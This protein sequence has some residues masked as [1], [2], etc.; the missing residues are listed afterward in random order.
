VYNGALDNAS[1][2]AFMLE[3]SK[4]I[5]SLG[6]P[7]RTII[8]IGFNAEE[9]G[10]LG[11]EHFA[12]KY[13]SQLKGAKVYNFD[14]IGSSAVPLTIMGGKGDN[15]KTEFLRS[16]MSTCIKE[17][18]DYNFIFED[19]SDHEAFRKNNIDAYL[20][21]CITA[22]LPKRI[23]KDSANKILCVDVPESIKKIIS[24]QL[25]ENRSVEFLSHIFYGDGISDIKDIKAVYKKLMEKYET[26]AELVITARLHCMSPCL[27]MG[28]PVI[29]V[30]DNC[31]PRMGWI[32]RYIP[33]YTP[34]TYSKI[35]WNPQPVSFE[36]T[37]DLMIEIAIDK[38][39]CAFKKYEKV[40]NLS[41]FY[42][43]RK[44]SEYGNFYVAQLKQLPKNLGNCF[45][46]IIW[47]TGQIGINAYN[48][49]T[50]IYPN[51]K[52]IAAVDSFC[53]GKFFEIDIQ[54]PDILKKYEDVYI[55][56]A[57]YSGEKYVKDF[58]LEL[59]KEN[60]KDYLSF[61]T[62]TG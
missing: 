28:I 51:S 61:A 8:F 40:C 5:K 12:I 7:E 15:D 50:E 60:I 55:F 48:V 17:K 23:K 9:F 2:I 19:S 26:E 46:Y 30:S 41:R 14:M 62:T 42:E 37:K 57:T 49:I 13:A 38:I 16:V 59:G 29:A 54:K 56:I 25:P 39:N 27:A 24:K 45:K 20:F 10:C 6:T 3:F 43:T 52:M 35:N 22:T 11:S 33:I 4:Y 31:S 21:G 53:E 1:G 18:V 47:G 58:L 34:E 32:D 36:D 44:K